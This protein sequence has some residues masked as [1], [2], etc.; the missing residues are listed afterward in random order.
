MNT[1]LDIPELQAVHRPT[2]V[3]RIPD[4]INVPVTRRVRR[5]IDSAALRRLAHVRQLGLVSLVYPAATH[6]RFEHCL[7]VYRLALLFLSRLSRDERFS[8]TVTSREAT[9]FVVAALLHDVG[10]WPFCHPIEDMGLP[11]LPHHEELARDWICAPGIADALREDF[12]LEPDDLLRLLLNRPRT[13][14]ERILV[15]MLSGPIDVDKL[16]YLARDSLHSGVPYGRNYDQQ[17]LIDSLCVSADGEGL[18][19]TEKGKTAAE[20]LVFARYVMFSEVYWHHAV[21]AATAMLQYAVFSLRSNLSLESLCRSTESQFLDQLQNAARNHE[22]QPLVDGLFGPQ[23]RLHKRAAEFGCFWHR[24]IYDRL[25][26]RPFDWLVRCS[27]ALSEQLARSWNEP[28]EP[29]EVLIDAPPVHREIEFQLD[30]WFKKESQFR[31]LSS[32]SPVVQAMA[33][34]QF[35]DYVKRV[36]VFLSPRLHVRMAQ[37]TNLLEPLSRAIEQVDRGAQAKSELRA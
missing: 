4:Q 13:A 29:L 3:I 6:F 18:A 2:D 27:Q 14:G 15:S 30:V 7:G 11:S 8:G 16:D 33:D 25:A 35:D 32:V 9:A 17:R 5:L 36:R 10:H 23:R 1:L 26:R 24:P 34:H 37:R 31:S 22:A 19:I 28:V 20:L 21:R 12:A